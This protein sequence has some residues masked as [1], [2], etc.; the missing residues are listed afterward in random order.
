M[1]VFSFDEKTGAIAE[2]KFGG[3][4][5]E[6][7]S[8]PRHFGFHPGGK[9]A[10]VINELKQTVT[11]FRYRAK[12]GRLQALQTISTVP[13]PVDGNSTAEVLVHPS[14]KF[15]YGSNRGHNSIAIFRID[16]K[17]GKLTALGHEPTRGEIPRNF[18]ID[19]TGQFLLAANQ[20][21]NNVAVFR[22]NRDTGKLTFT[23]NEIKL[24]KP[25]CV[26]M[27]LQK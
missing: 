22:I 20:R 17:T 26:R 13:H 16:E 4:K 23:G 27:I 21:S 18:G 5:L 12:H 1:L 11:A 8:G 10:Y 25:V 14:G 7:G 6:P 9:F 19:P 24:S 3:A 2:T 15:L